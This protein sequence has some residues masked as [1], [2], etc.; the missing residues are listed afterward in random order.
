MG[1]LFF[2]SALIASSAI[3]SLPLAAFIR[4][5]VLCIAASSVI[6]EMLLD[7]YFVTLGLDPKYPEM[8]L[9]AVNIVAI[10][11]T[12]LI[13]VSTVCFVFLARRIYRKLAPASIL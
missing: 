12:P 10:I 2:I 1:F 9:L 13:L 8:A 4:S 7:L 6:T 11:G 5:N 3:I